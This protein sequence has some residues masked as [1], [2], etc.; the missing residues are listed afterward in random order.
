MRIKSG[1]NGL[2]YTHEGNER[3]VWHSGNIT[4]LPNSLH[5]SSR[6]LNLRSKSTSSAMGIVMKSADQK[7]T[8][9]QIYGDTSGYGFLNADWGSWDLRKVKNGDMYLRIGTSNKLAMH[10]GNAEYFGSEKSASLSNG[11]VT[12]A[13]V[14][15]R[16]AF[17]IYVTNVDSSHHDYLRL[18]VVHSYD[19][20]GNCIK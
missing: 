1:V 3:K 19:R 11:W 16:S 14:K 9:F 10:S 6:N 20:T 13:R 17:E 2:T 4:P 5:D 8:G 15:N 7:H 12:V 18:S